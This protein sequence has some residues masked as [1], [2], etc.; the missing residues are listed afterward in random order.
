MS[1]ML[2][3]MQGRF[4]SKGG[5]FPQ[6][7][8]WRDW[9]HE[10]YMAQKHGIDCIEWMFNAE[11]FTE[12]PIW[13]V[14]GR[15]EVKDVISDTKVMVRSICANY[16]MQ[17]NIEE[18]GNALYILE[19][20][21]EAAAELDANQI[22]VPLFGASEITDVGKIYD[23]FGKICD[24]SHKTGIYIG[25]ESDIP[26]EDQRTVIDMLNTDNIGICYDVGNAAGNGCDVLKDITDIS[27]CLLEVHLKDKPF[28]GSSVML[29][30]GSV[31]FKEVF[32]KLN[33]EHGRIYI[34]E[35][36]F[37]KDAEKDTMINIQYIR[38]EMNG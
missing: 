6:E 21:V 14:T 3:T 8:P 20:L 9:R 33:N 25:F 29:G 16:F 24:I 22:I 31:K 30:E 2:G 19:H 17:Y 28:K 15:R 13:T 37:D 4:T 23:I 5:F 35:S 11:R 38:R 1:N 12:N 18:T 36:Y 7:F 27:E 32:K 10:F 26:V 34:L